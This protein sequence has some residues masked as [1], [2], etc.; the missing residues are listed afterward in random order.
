M[1]FAMSEHNMNASTPRIFRSYQVSNNQTPNCPIWQAL[2]ATTA[3][4]ELFKS[5]DIRDT[6][7]IGESLVGGDMGC[8]NPTP[9]VLAEVGALYSDR[10]IASI[11][12]IGSGHARTIHI[13]RPNPLHRIMPINVLTAMK[14]IATDNERVAQEMAM[15]F[16]ETAGVY[17]RFSVDQGMQDVR[18]SQWQRTNEV[19]AHTRAYMQ[20]VEVGGRLNEAAQS[21][22]ARRK[23]LS[24]TLVGGKVQQPPEQLTTGVKRCPAPSPVFT[25]C[26]HHISQISNCLSGA[27]ERRICVVHGLGGTGKTQIAL[28]VV[29]RTRNDWADIIYVDA[30]SRE[31]TIGTLKGFAVAKKIGD[32]HED[33]IRWLES[34]PQPWLLVFDNADDPDLGLPEFLPEGS[35][36]CVLITT[37]L[38]SL[39]LLGQGPGSDC[40]VGGMDGEEAVELLLKKA[41]M[42]DQVLSVEEVEAANKLVGDL[43]YL[44]LAIVHAGAYIWCSS[45]SIAK[46]R[47]RCLEHTQVALE[48]YSKMPGNIEKY[49]KTVYTT[50][51]MSY[52]RLKPRTQQLLVLMAYLHRDGIT[53]DIFK[54]AAGNTRRPLVIPP[55]DDETATRDYV[56]D[57]LELFLDADGHWD[58]NAFSALVDELLLYSLIDYDRVNEAYTLH[59]LVQ[60]WASAAAHHP[61]L[62]ALKHTLHLVALSVDESRDV[63]A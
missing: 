58:S 46:Y 61:K 44:A 47:K 45:I 51:L 37:R 10:H 60:D 27:A 15:R 35:H 3:H 62:V 59:M 32:T 33:A 39:A 56:R 8:S 38:R 20:R 4:P 23:A 12:C 54:R 6:S 25:G 11:V 1:V 30:T 26:E 63:S 7:G 42:Q 41:R 2:R 43:G 50:W 29:E 57:Y 9:H 17:F 52:E 18:T 48:K 49:D 5:I 36:G 31:T 53:E 24:T 22:V 40:N 13:P 19:V 14:N 34:S 16:Q 21:I 28:K 55:S